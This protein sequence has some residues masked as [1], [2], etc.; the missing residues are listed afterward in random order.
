MYRQA[1]E[2]QSFAP[3]DLQPYIEQRLEFLNQ[4]YPSRS[5]HQQAPLT[6]YPQ[7]AHSGRE[8]RPEWE[9]ELLDMQKVYAYLAKQT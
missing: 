2:G 5:L 9:A 7:V 1:I 3:A 6:A 8:Y 4:Y